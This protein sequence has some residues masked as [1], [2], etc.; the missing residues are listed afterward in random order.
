MSNLM[1]FESKNYISLKIWKYSWSLNV[2]WKPSILVVYHLW[3]YDKKILCWK[4]IQG[5]YKSGAVLEVQF[6]VEVLVRSEITTA[7]RA[8][9]W[10]PNML[11]VS[12][13]PFE[14]TIVSEAM[15]YPNS[16][17]VIVI[18]EECTFKHA[19][20]S[21][22]QLIHYVYLSNTV[23]NQWWYTSWRDV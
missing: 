14:K 10:W 12:I 7:P 11:W 20:H 19:D 9:P 2:F 17:H 15:W 1:H 21:I 4:S 8:A 6:Q 18:T 3:L 16:K 13:S 23:S 5:H 22:V